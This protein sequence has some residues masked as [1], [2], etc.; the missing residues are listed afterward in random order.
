MTRSARH[1][2]SGVTPQD[3][4][5]RRRRRLRAFG[6]SLLL[7]LLSLLFGV[8][9]VSSLI[10]HVGSAKRKALTREASAVKPV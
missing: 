4:R 8:G 3:I 9:T 7:P 10:C 5:R 2:E 6:M 1:K